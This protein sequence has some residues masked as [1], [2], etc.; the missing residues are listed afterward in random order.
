MKF[1]LFT[2]KILKNKIIHEISPGYIYFGHALT[3]SISVRE[4]AFQIAQKEGLV[5]KI[6]KMLKGIL[7]GTALREVIKEV[8]SKLRRWA[9]YFKIGNSYREALKLSTY[10]YEQ[11]RI[12][13]RRH[14]AGKNT[15]AYKKWTDKYFYQGGLLYVPYLIK[16]Y[17]ECRTKKGRGKVV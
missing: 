8:N 1:A 13:W 5:G 2:K 14:K 11:L 12:Y 6:K 9:E 15:K 17:N 3:Y 4:F 10:T 16:R 7:N